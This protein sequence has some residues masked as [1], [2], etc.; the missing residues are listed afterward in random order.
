MVRP[1]LL[2]PIAIFQIVISSI[3][4]LLFVLGLIFL[5]L[6]RY[7]SPPAADISNFGEGYGYLAIGT[8]IFFIFFVPH[9]VVA[10]VAGIGLLR[11]KNWARI[12][13]I[14]YAVF[15]AL[16]GIWLWLNKVIQIRDEQSFRINYSDYIGA[17]G[18]IFGIFTVVYLSRREVKEYFQTKIV[19]S[20]VIQPESQPT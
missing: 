15:T 3:F 16:P 12:L 14:A 18:T 20:S 7:L 5:L 2:I 19:Q 1:R 17:F 6:I 8:L 9:S 4:L 11:R 10:M 13:A